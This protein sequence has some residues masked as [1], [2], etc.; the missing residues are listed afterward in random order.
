MGNAPLLS[1][2]SQLRIRELPNFVPSAGFQDRLFEKAAK[3]TPRSR[4]EIILELAQRAGYVTRK[5]VEGAL[6]LK[7]SQAS[8]E[9]AKLVDEQLL[10]RQGKGKDVRY[11]LP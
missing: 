2:R 1:T 4:E 9:L 3:T 11:V 5:D 10:V 8:K 7:Q 6:D